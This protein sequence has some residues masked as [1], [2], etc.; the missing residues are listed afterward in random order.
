MYAFSRNNSKPY[1]LIIQ[2]SMSMRSYSLMNCHIDI[3][4]EN[5]RKLLLNNLLQPKASGD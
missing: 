2:F 3:D 5:K 1:N 4:I